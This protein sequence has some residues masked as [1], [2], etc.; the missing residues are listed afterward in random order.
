M[1][2]YSEYQDYRDSNSTLENF[3]YRQKCVEKC[4]E[5]GIDEKYISDLSKLYLVCDC[6]NELKENSNNAEEI[7][8]TVSDYVEKLS[9]SI[10]IDDIEKYTWKLKDR[11]I[12]ISPITLYALYM[13]E[14][15][16]LK[17]G[18]DVITFKDNIDYDLMKE[19]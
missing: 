16:I 1:Q 6:I 19:D 18:C 15:C 4:K 3:I 2:F 12:C 9:K 7:I 10:R 17:N 5:E 11:F 8:K 14:W 13:N